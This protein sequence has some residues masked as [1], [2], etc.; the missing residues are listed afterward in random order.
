MEFWWK[1]ALGIA[2]IFAVVIVLRK[3]AKTNKVLLGVG[4]FLFATIIGFNWIYERNEPK[5]ATPA[6]KW[7]AGFFPSKDT[8]GGH[9]RL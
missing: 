4:V 6:V 2:L 8:V 7:L 1:M 3:V 9:A 5:W